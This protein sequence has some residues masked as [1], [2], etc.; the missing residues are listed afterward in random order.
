MTRAALVPGRSRK[1]AKAGHSARDRPGSGRV[2][3]RPAVREGTEAASR[4]ADLPYRIT[5]PVAMACTSTRPRG[6]AEGLLTAFVSGAIWGP[7][8]RLRPPAEPTYSH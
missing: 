1:A 5:S 8:G 2:A 4:R 7:G 3:R 6:G